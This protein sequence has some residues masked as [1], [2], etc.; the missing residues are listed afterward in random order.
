MM[1]VEPKHMKTLLNFC[2]CENLLLVPEYYGGVN[3]TEGVIYFGKYHSSSIPVN[4]NFNL[5]YSK[6]CMFCNLTI[7]II[8]SAYILVY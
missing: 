5:M 3:I 2:N 8:I 7:I 1:I 6:L 4:F